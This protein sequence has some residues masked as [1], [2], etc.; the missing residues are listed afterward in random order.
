MRLISTKTEEYKRIA[1]KRREYKSTEREQERTAGA[2][3]STTAQGRPA[4]IGA[5]KLSPATG[6]EPANSAT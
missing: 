2:Q 5:G 3:D 6:E 1:K 4:T